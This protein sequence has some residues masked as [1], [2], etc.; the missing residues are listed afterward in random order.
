MSAPA[1]AQLVIEFYDLAA[2]TSSTGPACLPVRIV[3]GERDDGALHVEVDG[4]RPTSSTFVLHD[5]WHYWPP[6]GLG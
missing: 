3:K 6:I 1:V 2:H 4:H 5:D